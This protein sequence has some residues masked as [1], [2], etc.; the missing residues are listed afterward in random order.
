[1][2]TLTGVH[3][4]PATGEFAYDPVPY[5]GQRASEPGLSA[6]NGY[7][8]G[9]AKTDYALALDQL[10]SQHPECATVSLVCAWFCDGLDAATARVYPTTTYIG[11]AFQQAGGAPDFWRCSGLT[12]ASAGLIPMATA[13]DGSFAYGG[14]PS[15][16]SVVRCLRDLK[17]RGFRVV[18]YPFLL[19]TA[20]GL[21]WRGEIGFSPDK[22]AAATAAAQAFLGNA[23]PGQFARDAVNLT[24]SYG[25]AATDWTYRRMILHYANLCVIAGGVDLF[26][27]GSELRGLEILR[28]AGWTKAGTTD[29]SG[30]AVWDYPFVAGLA[31]LAGDVR[32][33]FDGA[34]LARDLAGLKNL[35]AYSADWSSWM[36]WQH[37]GE[38]GQWPHLDALY[39]SAAIDL[40]AFDNYLP[41]SDWTTGTGGLDALNWQA[42]PPSG[43]P[44][45]EPGARG[46]GLSGAPTLLS[47]AYLKA[48]IEGGEKFDWFY[49][50]SS[51]LGAGA[52]PGGSGLVVSRP[53]GDRLTQARKAYSAGQ[54]IL[55]NKQ[56]RWWW[57]H[58]HQA[59]YDT[60]GGWAAQGAA[61]GWV[62]QSKPIVFLE[63]GVPS[64][65][66]GTN[67]PNLFYAPSSSASGT[68]FWSIWS[69]AEG[70][71]LRPLRDDTIA[72]LGLD[73]IH[74]YWQANNASAG[75]VPMIAWDF[76]CVW[77]W[78]ARPFPT[79]P[80]RADV[81]GDAVN[82]AYGDWQAA[83]RVVT[84]PA[85]GSGDPTP[86]T[87]PSFPTLGALGW[88]TTMR[89]RFATGVA[90]H[91]SGRESRWAGRAAAVYELELTFDL[92]RAD[93]AAEL[94]AVAGFYAARAGQGGAFWLAPPGFAD[95]A[96]QSLGTG[97]GATTSFGLTR[98]FGGYVEPVLATG[99]VS[100]VYLDGTALATGWSV[101]PGFYPVIGFAAPPGAGV[102]VSAD[103][104]VLWLCRFAEDVAD[105]DN[106]LSLLWN[107]G[108]VKLRTVR[109]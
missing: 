57:G 13:A 44:V 58:S 63:Y 33:V 49:A 78:D 15:D 53:A 3:L 22:S 46:F 31:A 50:D 9:G 56:V 61:T 60:G 101:S 103:F 24:V 64:V 17:A 85:A 83:G 81:W 59:V 77:N 79:F 4:L 93:A 62:P 106:F 51:N 102:T 84:P 67:Q 105:F 40:V 42:A 70:E 11:G 25:G 41:L 107:W 20:A 19:M 99:G 108:G 86:G 65:D 34:G 14:T 29:A 16:A 37:P 109:P 32:A 47:K 72:S 96:G 23:A 87:Y 21:P 104:S 35:V 36:G 97:D 95:V 38:D 69:A 18:F 5:L 12:Q 98:S 45:G 71:A 89:P 27:I 52:D 100:A 39:G 68:P 74:E 26:V 82:W 55:A 7:A 92:L 43:W 30:H 1:M 2:A 6:I 94:Q 76:C 28:G 66:K 91:V 48:N 54:E 75:G 73:A 88:S 8:G 90:A 80:A 10:Q